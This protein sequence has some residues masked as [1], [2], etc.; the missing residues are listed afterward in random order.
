MDAVNSSENATFVMNTVN[1]VSNL[2]DV[3]I[4]AVGGL[5]P[6]LSAATTSSVSFTDFIYMLYTH[7]I[8]IQR[9][10][11]AV[12]ADTAVYSLSVLHLVFREKLMSWSQDMACP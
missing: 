12:S 1:L 3:L 2:S 11:A 6:L 7:D 8:S 4:T 10:G 9:G 5:L